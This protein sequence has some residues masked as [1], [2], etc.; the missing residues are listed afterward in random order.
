LLRRCRLIRFGPFP[1]GFSRLVSFASEFVARAMRYLMK[2]TAWPVKAC[3]CK[4]KRR[5]YNGY[6]KLVFH[7][8]VQ[9][10]VCI[11]G[12]YTKG[13]GFDVVCG[14]RSHTSPSCG[15]FVC[16]V[17]AVR[18]QLGVVSPG[19]VRCGGDFESK[20]YVTSYITFLVG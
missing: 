4:C 8:L 7:G 13:G 10:R 12:R 6:G 15:G 2:D 18:R 9:L 11:S 16:T 14:K 17:W 20:G 3:N 5:A 19:P 1:A